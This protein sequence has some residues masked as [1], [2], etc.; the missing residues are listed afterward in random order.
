M[1]I[2]TLILARGGS[3]GIKNKNIINIMGKPLIYYTIDIA[4]K[5]NLILNNAAGYKKIKKNQKKTFL[6]HHNF[7]YQFKK[8]YDQVFKH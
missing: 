4:K 2:I 1:N 3:K 8:S 6:N 7:E 5:I